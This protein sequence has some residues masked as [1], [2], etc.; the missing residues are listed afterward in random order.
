M[1]LW[2][3]RKVVVHVEAEIQTGPKRVNIECQV[4]AAASCIRRAPLTV[5]RA[6]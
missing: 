6:S 4:R 5:S 1:H 3:L 2:C